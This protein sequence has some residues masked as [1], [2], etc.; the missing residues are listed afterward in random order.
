MKDRALREALMEHG[1]LH[2]HK[3]AMSNKQRLSTINAERQ[4]AILYA[5]IDYLGL[6]VYLPDIGITIRKK[7]KAKNGRG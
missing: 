6:E 2:V 5:L 3:V 4:V 7:R 1:I